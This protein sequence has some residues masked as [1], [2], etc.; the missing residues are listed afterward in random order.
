MSS[1]CYLLRATSTSA[2]CD[3]VRLH[4]VDVMTKVFIALLQQPGERIFACLQLSA[5]AVLYNET[6]RGRVGCQTRR[7]GQGSLFCPTH[8]QRAPSESAM[9]C[10]TARSHDRKLMYPTEGAELVGAP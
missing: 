8:Q 1:E 6:E 10:A 2:T 3:M 4:H 5:S 7:L 9:V